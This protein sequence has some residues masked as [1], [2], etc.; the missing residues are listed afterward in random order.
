MGSEPRRAEVAGAGIAGLTAAAALAQRGW[1]VRV[2]ERNTELRELGA[3]I[4]VWQN[5][6][7]AL[8]EIDALAEVAEGSDRLRD[9]ELRDHRNRVL[10][11][12]WMLPGVDESYAVLRTQLHQALAH[13]AERHGVEILTDSAVASASPD[14]EMVLASGERLR[15]DLIVGADGIN[16]RVRQSSGL[17]GDVR[18]LGDGC[19]R[20]LVPRLPG[21]HAESIIERWDGGRR[22]GIMP[23]TKDQVYIFLCCPASDKAG[24]AQEDGELSTWKESFP[25][26]SEFIDR[27]P[28]GGRWASFGDVKV[29]R[30][31]NGR[32]ALVGDAAHAMS[33]NLGQAA[34]C[35]MVNAVALSRVLD[36]HAAIESALTEWER[37]ERPIT[38]V[39]QRYSRFYGFIGTH[40]PRPLVDA[41]SALIWTLAHSKRAQTRINV[42]A[43]YEPAWLEG[44]PKLAA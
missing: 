28:P 44:Q 8:R 34:C 21:D 26:F 36:D 11:H 9:W 7:I 13:A 25:E 19:G 6:V 16:S 33:P 30:W 14:G 3:G 32:V 40:W 42:A 20:H 38:D 43:R 2:H 22:I 31:S 37:V 29:D 35:A 24:R 27:I 15:A 41:R 1:Q 23:C 12:E 5:G 4:L 39:T 17:K 10:Q 18:D